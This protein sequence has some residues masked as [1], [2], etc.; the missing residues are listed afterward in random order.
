M[1][2]Q[3]ITLAMVMLG[4]SVPASAQIYESSFT[5]TNGIEVHAPSTRMLLNPASPVTLT[6]IAGL[7]R[8]VNVKVTSA[9]G[10]QLLNTTTTRT[11][12]SDRLKAGDGTEFYGKKVTLPALGE[13]KSVVQVSIL[14]LNQSVVATYSYNWLIDTT[15][16]TGN[17][18][19]ANAGN[20]S[21]SGNVWKLGLE[22]TGQ[23]DFTSANVSDVNGIEKGLFYV[24]RSDGSLYST[25]QMQ[26]DVTGK[27]MYH[28]YSKNTTKGVGIPDSNLDEDFTAKVEIYDNAGNRRTLPIQLFRYDNVLGEMTLWAVHDPQ[29]SA[30]VVPG[31]SGY[32]AYSAGMTINENPIRLVY[33]LPKSNY[34]AYAEG[35]CNS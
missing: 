14:D 9:T 11:S 24:Y 6:V 28:T 32:P 15:P 33:R 13:G 2:Y 5:D 18:L 25:T 10:T 3:T 30:S 12:V 16:P 4:V 31:V 26:Y 17:A 23:W 20:G 34:R 27:K 19:T 1:K 22:A 29:T 21:A 35:G 8:Y 7:D